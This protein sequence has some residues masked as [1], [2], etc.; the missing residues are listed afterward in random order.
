MSAKLRKGKTKTIL[1]SSIDSALLAV[2]IYNKPRA[3]FRSEAF[4]SLMVISWT[5]LFHA[6]FHHTIGDKYYYKDKKKPRRYELIDGEKK[7]WELSACINRYANLPEP[8]R[9][10]L[11][12]LIKLRNKIEHRHVDIR[13]V[14]ALIFGECQALL[15][16][17]ENLLRGLFGKEY[18]LNESLVYSLQFSQLRTKGQLKASKSVLSKDIKNIVDYVA[19][20]RS[21]LTDD[22]YNSQEYSIKLLMIPKVSN[23]NRTDLAIEY[24]NFDE[25]SNEDK[26]IYNQITVLV[27][28][29]K[30]ITEGSNVGRLKPGKVVNK[31]NDILG[32]GTINQ[33]THQYFYTIF[34]VRPKKD[35][36][37]PF[38]TNTDYCH[39]DEA[40]GDYV[41]NDEWVKLIIH[42]LQTGALEIDQIRENF[43]K[44]EKLDIK[45]Y[46]PK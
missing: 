11:E 12:F 27:K 30:I 14:D 45:N 8:V 44:K 46:E 43:I 3:S 9:K 21:S 42:I 15:Y 34:D 36:E 33:R 24:V 29:R 22:V 16:N 23:T 35:H 17:Y 20:Y 4:I 39:Y 13:E 18:A 28:D 10:N 5:R 26:E 6:Y 38:E 32:K 1:E 41:Y 31:V 37:D 40:H 25:L 7:A 19:K 2:E